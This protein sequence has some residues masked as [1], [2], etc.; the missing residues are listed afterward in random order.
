MIL[1]VNYADHRMTR[2]QLICSQSAIQFGVE[3]VIPMNPQMISAAFRQF[4]REILRTERGAGLWLWKPY[5]IFRTMLNCNNGDILIYADAGVEFINSV[6]HIIGRMEEDIFLFTNTHPNHHWTKRHVLDTMMPGWESK[7]QKD[8]PWPQVQASVIFFRV[9]DKAKA[10]VKEWLNYCQM[11]GMID[12]SLGHEY[13]FF[14]DHRH[15]QSILTILAYKA[16]YSL[17]W[18]P[19]QYSNH[20]PR[21]ERDSYPIIFNHTRKRNKGIGKGEPEWD[22]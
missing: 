7:Y 4:N 16:G 1:L 2:S 21:S 8:T 10:F 22:E 19:T 15:D 13:P 3:T 18:W 14:Q 17:H 11:P 5:C 20:L 9:N 6:Q 12:D